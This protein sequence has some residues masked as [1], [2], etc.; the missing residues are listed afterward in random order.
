[1]KKLLFLLIPFLLYSS[2]IQTALDAANKGDYKTAISILEPLEKK[3]NVK[4]T[5]AM[6]QMRYFGHGV[7]KN[8]KRAFGGFFKCSMTGHPGAQYYLGMMLLFGEGTKQNNTEAS[9]WLQKS[10]SGGF[11][12]ASCPLALLYIEGRGV[13]KS[14]D[15]ATRLLQIGTLKNLDECK[16]IAKM[17]KIKS[18]L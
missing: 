6:S 7:K 2:N 15:K 8:L 13:P 9:I 11:E 3:G 4:A 12:K 16:N 1:M 5:Y 10:V 17:Y 18:T 14:I